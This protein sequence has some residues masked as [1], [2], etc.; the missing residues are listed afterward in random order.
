MAAA[1]L[2]LVEFE[3]S[4]RIATMYDV[5]HGTPGSLFL[6]RIFAVAAERLLIVIFI[7]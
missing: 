6:F 3:H 5:R 2:R 7:V 1:A 4:G